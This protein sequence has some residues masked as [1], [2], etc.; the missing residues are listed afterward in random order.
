MGRRCYR[1]RV[2][3][4]FPN[5]RNLDSVADSPT[6]RQRHL[7]GCCRGCCSSVRDR[8][9]RPATQSLCFLEGATIYCS[10]WS[11]RSAL[12][13]QGACCQISRRRWVQLGA[14]SL[15]LGMVNHLVP[16]PPH[17]V[18]CSDYHHWGVLQMNSYRDR[19]RSQPRP[20]LSLPVRGER[21]RL[22]QLSRAHLEQSAAVQCGQPMKNLLPCERART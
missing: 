3:S 22:F 8:L 6:V 21:P 14:L 13:S 12:S 7:Q 16:L 20:R 1:G 18:R 4:P 5:T 19:T 9:H 11:L 2:V 17:F 15:L 10:F